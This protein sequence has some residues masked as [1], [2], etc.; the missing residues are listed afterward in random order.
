M[1]ETT[2][3]V[4]SVSSWTKLLHRRGFRKWYWSCWKRLVGFARCGIGR[5]KSYSVHAEDL[6]VDHIRKTIL[7]APKDFSY[8]D[9]G[10]HHPTYASN[11]C[12]FYVEGFR[13]INIEPDPELFER[14]VKE[15]PEDVNLNVG[16][17]LEK[18]DETNFYVMDDR[19]CSTFSKEMCDY[20]IKVGIADL[21]YVLRLPLRT[22]ASVLEE[23]QVRPDFVT[24]D[25][26]GLDF[27]ILQTWD[28][29][30]SRP[31]VFC[32]ETNKDTCDKILDFMA[33]KGYSV[34]AITSMN[35]I[36]LDTALQNKP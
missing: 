29:S 21:K 5:K 9:I 20:F 18:N 25:C 28:F 33:G 11:T 27:E 26:E 13:G 2:S 32:V 14:F 8:L 16:I 10:A 19:S 6:I 30:A 31:A 7:G 34:Y 12:L 22:V 24:I 36:F 15:R 35:T 17:G 1:P 3:P 4:P 23:H